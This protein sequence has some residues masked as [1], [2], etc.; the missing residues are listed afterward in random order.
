MGASCV[1]P[2]VASLTGRSVFLIHGHTYLI[3]LFRLVNRQAEIHI[4]TI[5]KSVFFF[6]ILNNLLVTSIQL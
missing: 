4:I 3:I 5:L 1:L 6:R 2:S